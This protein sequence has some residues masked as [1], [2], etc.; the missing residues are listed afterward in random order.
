MIVTEKYTKVSNQF[1][2]LMPD[3]KGSVTK[4]MLA[5]FRASSGHHKDHAYISNRDFVKLTG[6]KL[7]TVNNAIKDA[8]AGGYLAVDPDRKG[9]NGKSCYLLGDKFASDAAYTRP[10]TKN[11]SQDY[12]S[13]PKTGQYIY[14]I[15][16]SDG[17]FK[18]GKTTQPRKR[19]RKLS[20]VLPFD[21]KVLHLI[22]TNDMSFVEKHLHEKYQ[23]KRVRGEWFALSIDDV[24]EI[25][26]IH[27]IEVTS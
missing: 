11:T 12:S 22:P 25:R 18:I 15:Q 19:L 23:H 24:K 26:E 9:F 27:S 7:N 3:M 4:I 8:V 10:Q 6:L 21:I 20:V 1:F 17:Y 13:Y 2:E 16:G 5:Y 14:L